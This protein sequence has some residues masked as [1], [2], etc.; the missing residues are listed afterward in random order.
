M[1]GRNT[2]YSFHSTTVSGT[3]ISLCDTVVPQQL[4]IDCTTI[5]ELD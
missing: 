2:N 3:H 5:V 4:T 1:E